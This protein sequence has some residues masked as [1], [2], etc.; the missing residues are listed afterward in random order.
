[1]TQR[2]QKIK[3]SLNTFFNYTK[4]GPSKFKVNSNIVNFERNIN[5]NDNNIPSC[6]CNNYD[7]NTFPSKQMNIIPRFSFA[8]QDLGSG[9]FF[10]LIVFLAFP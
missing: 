5:E 1:M 6:S 9:A 7:G 10:L 2:L 4:D 8:F 3:K